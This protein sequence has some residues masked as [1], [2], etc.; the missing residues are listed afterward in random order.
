MK[1][2]DFFKLYRDMQLVCVF[3]R[4]IYI[5]IYMYVSIHISIHICIYTVHGA[6]IWTT[7]GVC[8][9]CHPRSTLEAGSSP[10]QFL[11]SFPLGIKHTKY[12]ETFTSNCNFFFFLPFRCMRVCDRSLHVL[13]LW[14][15]A[16]A[17]MSRVCCFL[18]FSQL[19]N[20]ELA[21]FILFYFSPCLR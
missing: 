18:S 16:D 11:F 2:R 12:S 8:A 4:E 19:L 7:R 6:N 3:V 20:F 21:F 17:I 13:F 9:W 10:C 5:Y 14:W 1:R 15:H